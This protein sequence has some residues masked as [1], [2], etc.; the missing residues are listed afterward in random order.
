[1]SLWRFSVFLGLAM[2]A[3]IAGLA[4]LKGPGLFTLDRITGPR[5]RVADYVAGDT[6]TRA[7]AEA[8]EVKTVVVPDKP[9]KLP[10]F[11]NGPGTPP[12][13][14][15]LYSESMPVNQQHT[16]SYR[17]AIDSIT[18]IGCSGRLV[19]LKVADDTKPRT[20][21]SGAT[22]QFPDGLE[23]SARISDSS[24]YRIVLFD[25]CVAVGEAASF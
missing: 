14:P 5:L 2:V 3:L 13:V 19:A 6:S 17:A 21:T 7:P 12:P 22:L 20:L 25:H 4:I 11:G 18:V 8:G 1:M 23:L 15:K 10:S 9:V 24:R 16:A